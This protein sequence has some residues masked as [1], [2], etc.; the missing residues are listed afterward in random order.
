MIFDYFVKEFWKHHQVSWISNCTDSYNFQ[1]KYLGMMWNFKV[2]QAK[3]QL[4]PGDLYGRNCFLQ[5]MNLA[6]K[7]CRKISRNSHLHSLSPFIFL[8]GQGKWELFVVV[9]CV[10]FHLLRCFVQFLFLS[11]HFVLYLHKLYSRYILL[12]YS[13]DKANPERL[14]VY[15]RK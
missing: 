10:C 12:T 13:L 14:Q 7:W 2:P 6:S 9:F 4:L 3:N 5:I 8:T 1:Y 11:L 15:S